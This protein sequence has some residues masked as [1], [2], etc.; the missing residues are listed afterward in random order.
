MNRKSRLRVQEK[1]KKKKKTRI[2]LKPKEKTN[3][4][5]EKKTLSNSIKIVLFDLIVF[6]SFS[7]DQYL[8]MFQ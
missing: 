5:R 6:I 2:N 8:T 3:H 7:T 1:T 4:T